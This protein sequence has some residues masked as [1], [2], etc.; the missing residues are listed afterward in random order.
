MATLDDKLMGEKLH[1][2][3]SSS[4][5]EDEAP[6]F[7]KD[8]DEVVPLQNPGPGQ[9]NT[10]P[11]GVIE[12]WRRYKQLE[13]E[14]RA[15]NER[16]K[17]A[18]AKKLALTCRSDREDQE[19]NKEM[20]ALELEEEDEFIQEYMKKRMQEMVEAAVIQRKHF[21]HVFAL[22]DGESFL[23]TVDCKETK[24]DLIV[25]LIVE[26]GSICKIM[27]SCWATLAKEYSYVKFC[28][29]QASAAGLSKHFKNSGVPAILVYRSGDLVHSFVRLADTLG[30][31]FYASDL[32]SFLIENGVLS[33]T[34]LTASSIKGPSV[35]TQDS[36]S[37]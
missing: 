4:E 10:G 33:E 8:G 7:V 37:D 28:K 29:I 26:S 23:S 18:L 20:E 17:V 3:C 9:A 30:E 6:K 35:Q 27:E 2:Y 21:G 34:K 5:D 11:K 13:T 1:Y 36:D 24:S 12:D 25:V 16:E 32:E 14:K 19:I 22:Q 15:E 31:D